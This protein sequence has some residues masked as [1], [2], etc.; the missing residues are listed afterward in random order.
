M[1]TIKIKNGK[2]VGRF[3]VSKRDIY[4]QD[5]IIK[6]PNGESNFTADEEVDASG[7]FLLPGFIETHIHGLRQCD[8]I[9]G[10]V[11]NSKDDDDEAYSG[12]IEFILK[13]LPA[14]GITTTLLS[15]FA[16]SKQ[17]LHRFLRNGRIVMERQQQAAA[18]L[19]GLDLEGNFLKDPKFSGYQ[20]PANIIAPSVEIFKELQ[21]MAGGGIK[22]ALVAPEWGSDAFDLIKYI[23]MNGGLPSIGHTGCSREEMLKAYDCGT[24]V[25]VHTGNG[26][27]SQNFKGGGALD[28]IFELGNKLYGEIICD[29]RHVHH[30][31]VNTFI[32]CFS[33]EK[34]VCVS[35]TLR[36][37]ASDLK[38]GDTI[39]GLVVR[40]GAL[41]VAAKEN[42]LAGSISTLDI[43]FENMVNLLTTDRKAYF[44]SE[45]P[46]PLDF[47]A[48]LVTLSRMYSYNQACMLGIDREVGS[49]EDG[50]K[51]DL[52]LSKFSNKDG[53][54]LMDIKKVFVGGVLV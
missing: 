4:L 11:N 15:S 8:C 27:M 22:K 2:V 51:A 25:V 21:D 23:A 29:M 45:V 40:D 20:D 12:A 9:N 54:I 16:C 30:R 52:V 36:Y 48:A 32:N 14:T 10:F 43:Q 3:G 13:S 38:S 39:D 18:R 19:T 50:K 35:D 28:G 7:L 42:T 37:A 49:V 46:A 17:K 41:W 47:E 24:R 44:Q 34:T 5:G 1:K 6:M 33:N 31:W 26:P 53:R